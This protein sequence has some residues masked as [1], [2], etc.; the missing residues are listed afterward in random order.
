[1]AAVLV[2]RIPFWRTFFIEIP[3]RHQIFHDLTSLFRRKT[4]HRIF[5]EIEAG[6]DAAAILLAEPK[7]LKRWRGEWDDSPLIAAIRH[8]RSELACK[9]LEIGGTFK[10]DGVLER[11]AMKGDLIVVKA[12][13]F[14]KNPN[15]T[16]TKSDF[17]KGYTP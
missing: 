13:V 5:E 1:M 3:E 8:G 16:A 11:A 15:E 9:L 14:G 2:L 7:G 10:D 4:R 6:N 12:L 17:N